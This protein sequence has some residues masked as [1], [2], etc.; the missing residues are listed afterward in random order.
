M[1]YNFKILGLILLSLIALT[2]GSTTDLFGQIFPSLIRSK[3]DLDKDKN[4][5]VPITTQNFDVV[6]YGDELQGVCAAIWAKKTLGEEGK[7]ALVRSNSADEPLGGLLTRGGLAFLDYDKTNWYNQ[8]VAQCFRD[9]LNRSQVVVSCLAADKAEQAM[10]EMLAE[11]GVS[12]INEAPL[13]PQVEN[14]TIQYVD[15]PQ[16][17]VR[18]QA[19]SYIDTTQDAEL[20]RKAGLAYYRGYESQS[21]ELANETLAVSLVP[22]ITG[23]TIADLRAIERQIFSNGD[24]MKQI[25]TNIRE[26]TDAEGARF[27]LS[28]FRV[29]LYKSSPDGYYHK[30]IAFGVAYKLHRNLPFG[31]KGFFL[32]KSNICL[33][34]DNSLSWNGLLFK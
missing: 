25:E 33:L 5:T 23:L 29:P 15:I 9:F 14:Q 2:I 31:L 20:A 13:M 3:Q 24:L 6:V 30:S 26:N 18:L 32:D 4:N 27:W 22:I 12:I 7:V 16:S 10:A 17:N 28:N 8:P 34:P 21:P 1:T 11:A 19:N